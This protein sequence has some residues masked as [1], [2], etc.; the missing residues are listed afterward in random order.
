MKKAAVCLLIAVLS[1]CLCMGAGLAEAT[2]ITWQGH[3]LTI[4]AVTTESEAIAK[5]LS[6]PSPA[7]GYHVLFL[8]K[9]TDGSAI[10]Q[11]EADDYGKDFMLSDGA[12]GIARPSGLALQYEGYDLGILFYV[13]DYQM[14]PETLHLV[15]AEQAR[16]PKSIADATLSWQGLEL[17]AVGWTT[18]KTM[19]S[20]YTWPESGYLARVTFGTRDIPITAAQFQMGQY[21]IVLLDEAGREYICTA[22]NMALE[23]NKPTEFRLIYTIDDAAMPPDTLSCRVRPLPILWFSS[24]AKSE[25]AVP[26]SEFTPGEPKPFTV[27]L[28]LA[29]EAKHHHSARVAAA[30]PQK[31]FEQLANELTEIKADL[32]ALLGDTITIT[33]DPNEAS[34]LIFVDIQY[35]E[36]G[37]YGTAGAVRAHNCVLTLTAYDAFTH[38]EIAAMQAANRFGDTISV[39]PGTSV[40]A[41]EIPGIADAA[42][43]QRTAFLDSLTIALQER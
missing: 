19:L 12:N 28:A 38:A 30:D 34:A 27:A 39:T 35:P 36:A 22:S 29:N 9:L 33:S 31:A 14:R 11:A 21:E 24:E 40:V 6:G 26:F 32:A 23:Q 42:Q 8:L 2:A 43:E 37:K 25:Y 20:H 17:S 1:M 41:K 16:M 3:E 15:V 10:T 18:D 7:E 5:V 13:R 4:E